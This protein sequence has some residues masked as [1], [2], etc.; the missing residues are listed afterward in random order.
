MHL[1]FLFP[2]LKGMHGLDNNPVAPFMMELFGILTL[3]WK[4]NSFLVSKKS[5]DIY[6]KEF[7][8]S[9]TI[10]IMS[11]EGIL[12]LT[13]SHSSWLNF[14]KNTVYFITKVPNICKREF[15]I[16]SLMI[17]LRSV[18]GILNFTIS[19]SSSDSVALFDS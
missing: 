6:Q 7:I 18:E 16:K 3:F 19:H 2:F 8:R 13:I 10:K 14:E 9:L 12:N 17:Y 15:I 4:E 1:G 5:E 11:V